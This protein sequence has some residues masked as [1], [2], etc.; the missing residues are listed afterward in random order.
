MGQQLE[1]AAGNSILSGGITLDELTGAI[2]GTPN[3]GEYARWA[4]ANTLEARSTA[5]VLSDIGAQASD[6]DLT[7]IAALTSAADKVPYATGA[8]TWAL[9]DLTAAGRALLDDA[10]AAAQLV[11][12]GVAAAITA[13]KLDDLAT[14]DDNTDL[15]ASSARH[16]LCP[17]LSNVA[18]EYL[19]G[20]GT[21]ATPGAGSS[22]V[23]ASAYKNANQ[24]ITAQTW[25]AITL[26]AENFDSGT[27]HSTSS[28]TGRF[29]VP[30]TGYYLVAANVGRFGGA[31]D[32]TIKA[33]I[34]GVKADAYGITSF[35]IGAAYNGLTYV[36]VLPLTAGDYVEMY[37]QT[38]ATEDIVY[39]VNTTAATFYTQGVTCISVVK[40]G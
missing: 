2:S 5:Q 1:P 33:Y 21:W 32:V 8:G 17:K 26:P 7:A 12:L 37:I 10:D 15:N 35:E 11:T 27:I 9:A 34:N 25:T 38:Y 31:E 3:A 23:G 30:T 22:F 20:T 4:D 24:T 6:T 40:V 18:T 14:P 29:T 19:T 39:D 36:S 28:N 16:G 13:T